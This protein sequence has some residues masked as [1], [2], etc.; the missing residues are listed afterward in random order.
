RHRES[1]SDRV[2]GILL[3]PTSLPA[4][5]GIGDF[6]PTAH[7]FVEFLAASHQRLWQ[8][9]PLAPVGFGNSP[10]SAISAFAGNPL[11]VSLERLAD[12]G[13]IDHGRLDVLPE[14][15][16]GIDYEH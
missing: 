9:L 4:R 7:E 13:W 2:S 15:F 8:I 16:L 12:Y 14:H 1:M 6:G 11:L 5:G 3:H 10:Y